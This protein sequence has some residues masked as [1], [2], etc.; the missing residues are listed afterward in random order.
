[1]NV[2]TQSYLFLLFGGGLIRLAVSDALLRYV[3]PVARPWVV[4]AG[5]SMVLLALAQL[6]LTHRQ[7]SAGDALGE[8]GRTGEVQ[9]GWLRVG[10][11]R[12]GWLLLAP[13]VAI[14]V[15]AP[16][17]LGSYSARHSLPVTASA[18]VHRG[19]AQLLGPSPHPMQLFDF[20]T[21]VLWDSGSTLINTD[22]K[23][24]GFVLSQRSSGFVLARLVITCCAADARPAE[25]FVA[26][27]DRPPDDAWVTVTGR[28]AGVDASQPD[29]PLVR[30][31]GV[32][33]V[34]APTN[35]YD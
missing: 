24:T 7:R 6:A 16:P 2:R 14:L 30:A 9:V 22:V 26:S 12:V 3:R 35:P 34:A 29:F 1:M 10:G 5:I 21:R 19:F 8:R 32:A 27:S 25:V 13:V 28:Y 4:I 23:L 11:V 18:D 33:R 17:A 20:T 15:I 31:A